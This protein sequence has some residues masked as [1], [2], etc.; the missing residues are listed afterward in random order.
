M[1][2]R[3]SFYTVVNTEDTSE[4][5]HTI[6]QMNPG[7]EIF[8]G[9]FPGQPVVPGVCMLQMVKELAE[10]FSGTSLRLINGHDLKFLSVI[11]PRR[12]PLIYAETQCSADT[13]G[14]LAVISRFYYRDLTFFK[15]KG[16]F[17]AAS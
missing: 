3:D 9:H 7:H 11:D 4:N 15:F 12:H 6:M 13:P 14:R 17:S 16:V 8:S 2:L 1:M 5:M 10:T